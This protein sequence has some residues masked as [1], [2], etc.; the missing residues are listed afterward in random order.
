MI[1]KHIL[2]KRI[3]PSIW[4]LRLSL[5]LLAIILQTKLNTAQQIQVNFNLEDMN[6][7]QFNQNI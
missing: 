2:L 4:L 3:L 6:G 7:N 1:T 5:F